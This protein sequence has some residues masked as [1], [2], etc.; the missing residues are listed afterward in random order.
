MNFSNKMKINM[1]KK[2]DINTLVSRML[3]GVISDEER[4][5]LERRLEASPELRKQVEELMDAD[6]LVS[7][8]RLY[9]SVEPKNA[10]VVALRREDVETQD[11]KLTVTSRRSVIRTVA[12][13]A[14]VALVVFAGWTLFGNQSKQL[15][16]LSPEVTQ[17]MERM[18]KNGMEGATLIMPGKKPVSVANAAVVMAQVEQM[19]ESGAVEPQSEESVVEGVLLTRHD[20]EFWM[21]LDD[22]TY[23]HLN[24]NTRLTYP[25]HFSIKERRVK[26]DGEAYF[27]I[28]ND[29]RHR[30]FIVETAHG[31]VRDY[32]TEFNVST[33]QAEHTTSVVLVKGKVSVSGVR[34]EEHFLEPGEM[35]TVQ[36]GRAPEINK[37]DTELYTSWNTGNFFFDGC[38]LQELMGVISRWYGK[39]VEFAS[40]DIQNIPFTGSIDKYEPLMPALHAIESITGLSV[41]VDGERILISKDK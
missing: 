2:Q 36:Q 24:Y 20:K 18:E 32:G 26:L 8:Y 19:E 22:G 27:V 9:Q 29:S 33:T 38:T 37:V 34:G 35:A 14:V 39:Q 6:D 21:R 1:S 30:P 25:N 23:V 4:A 7:R 17:A 3:T 11:V 40:D 13:A 41:A 5:D 15:A 12:A 28:A 16:E 31:M 10:D